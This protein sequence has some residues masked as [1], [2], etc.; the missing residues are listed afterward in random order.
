MRKLSTWLPLFSL[1][2]LPGCQIVG[3]FLGLFVIPLLPK[4]TIPAEHDFSQK[5]LLIWIDDATAGASHPHLPRYLTEALETELKSHKAVGALVDYTRVARFRPMHPDYA[6]ISIAELGRTFEADEVLYVQI[7]QF[8]FD[9]EAG[10]GYYQPALTGSVKVINAATGERLWPAN[11][12]HRP[13]AARGDFTEGSGEVIETRLLRG[14]AQNV[15][16]Q[17]APAFYD[18]KEK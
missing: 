13:I 1:I 7:D 14:L 8:K 16:V 17:L 10:P 9:H 18:H 4:K 5:T 12:T 11:Q 6:A 15:A 2:F 3:G